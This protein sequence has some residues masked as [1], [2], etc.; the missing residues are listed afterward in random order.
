MY[1]EIPDEQRPEYNH[2]FLREANKISLRKKQFS[3]NLLKRREKLALQKDYTSHRFNRSLVKDYQQRLEEYESTCFNKNIKSKI[4]TCIRFMIQE[5]DINVQKLYLSLL[6]DI[7]DQV[8]ST[9]LYM[10]FDLSSY[11]RVATL[12]L[13]KDI[14]V[15]FM[16]KFSSKQLIY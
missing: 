3:Q 6:Y 5:K 8:N 9:E 10:A 1:K 12:L 4:D 11:D 15:S 2:N 16:L 7:I 14:T 13:E